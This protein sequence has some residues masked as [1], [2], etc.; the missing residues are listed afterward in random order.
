MDDARGAASWVVVEAR[1]GHA[2]VGARSTLA[3][4]RHEVDRRGR[5]EEAN[6]PQGD[7][8]GDG[9]APDEG[10]GRRLRARRLRGGGGLPAGR[11]RLP[12]GDASPGTRE[13]FGGRV[14]CRTY[15]GK[16]GMSTMVLPLLRTEKATAFAA[17]SRQEG[18][19]PETQTV[20]PT[21]QLVAPAGSC[22]ARTVAGRL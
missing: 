14:H 15:P 16:A 13:R 1:L 21:V 4:A 2:I 17:G 10:K 12:W 9:G 11:A 18:E 20:W 7:E 3:G 19:V 6:H 5:H 22:G 8:D